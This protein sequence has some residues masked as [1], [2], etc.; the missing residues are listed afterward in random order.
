MGR[1][2]HVQPGDVKQMLIPSNLSLSQGLRC[3]QLRSR[4]SKLLIA[5]TRSELTASTTA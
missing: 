1:K 5:L 3:I 2:V 4:W